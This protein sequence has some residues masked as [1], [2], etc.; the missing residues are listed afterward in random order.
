[1]NDSPDT[2]LI[3]AYRCSDCS[4]EAG[5][6]SRRR[7]LIER[8]I[9]PL[10]LLRPVRCSECFR[11]DYRLI[12]VQVRERL[13]DGPKSEASRSEASKI[14]PGIMP[15][16]PVAPAKQSTPSSRNVA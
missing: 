6:R 14:M 1:M 7:T 16:K 4:S 2:P 11:R 5:F 12:F 10:L 8:F 9:L 13:S 15:G 3:L